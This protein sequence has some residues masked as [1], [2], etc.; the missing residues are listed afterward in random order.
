MVNKIIVPLILLMFVS[1][2]HQLGPETPSEIQ[3][4]F[5]DEYGNVVC[6]NLKGDV[7]TVTE[8]PPM[9]FSLLPYPNPVKYMLN[10]RFQVPQLDSVKIDI[11]DGVTGT[12]HVILD[13]KRAPG[14]HLLLYHV[15]KNENIVPGTHVVRMRAS[16]KVYSSRIEVLPVPENISKEVQQIADQY[17][18]HERFK[19]YYD[20]IHAGDY[21]NTSP[22]LIWTIDPFSQD[23][24]YFEEQKKKS[25]AY[26]DM[27]SS[28]NQFVQGWTD[29]NPDM[30]SSNF[31]YILNQFFGTSYDY[32]FRG[33]AI[34]E[35]KENP[36]DTLWMHYH[37]DYPTLPLIL[38]K[39]EKQREMYLLLN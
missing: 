22:F 30:V 25:P 9:S 10:I 28:Y 16:N 4:I 31:Q 15:Y 11:I 37:P 23:S 35:V 33:M 6:R 26:Y 29:V 38:G 8:M 19:S 20:Y 12:A 36:A 24:L 39:S 14:Y 7:E 3:Y 21:N 27:I 2:Y 13:K 34:K 5:T 17:Y 1:C 18:S 32:R